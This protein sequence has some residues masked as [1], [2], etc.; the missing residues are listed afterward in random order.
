MLFDTTYPSLRMGLSTC[1]NP[2]YRGH[3]LRLGEDQFVEWL[4]E[5]VIIPVIVDMLFDIRKKTYEQVNHSHN[6]CYRGHALRQ[7]ETTSQRLP[8][9]RS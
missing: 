9:W 6:P 5:V 4:E 8:T 7:E 1:H 3:A 2:C